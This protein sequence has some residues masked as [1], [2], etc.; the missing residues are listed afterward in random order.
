[1]CRPGWLLDGQ[2]SFGVG[3]CSCRFLDEVRLGVRGEL[4][5]DSVLRVVQRLL[6]S[7]GVLL[8]VRG[9]VL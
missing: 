5:G 6:L 7:V 2:V 3:R 9:V 1:M 4:H 8:V